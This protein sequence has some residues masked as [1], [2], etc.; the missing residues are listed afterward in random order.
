MIIK[1]LITRF[2]SCTDPVLER[3]AGHDSK[4]QDIRRMHIAAFADIL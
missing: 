1:L 3:I 4:E 2:N